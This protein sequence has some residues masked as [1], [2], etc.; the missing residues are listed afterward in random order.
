MLPGI[1]SDIVAMLVL[2]PAVQNKFKALAKDYATKN[3]EK[4]MQ[5]VSSRMG[6]ID[7]RN[8]AAWAVLIAPLVATIHLRANSPV[9][10]FW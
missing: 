4:L 8:L 9:W 10:W 2:L 5:M 6:G 7:P 3:P 1:L